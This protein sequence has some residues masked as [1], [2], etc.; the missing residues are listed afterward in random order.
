VKTDLPYILHRIE[1]ERPEKHLRVT[2][3]LKSLET[4]GEVEKVVSE[5]D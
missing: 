4:A 2:E 3:V 1:H 5:L